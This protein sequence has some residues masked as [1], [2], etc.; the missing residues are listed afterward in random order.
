VLR[1]TEMYCDRGFEADRQYCGLPAFSEWG[2]LTIPLTSRIGS[3][4]LDN[5]FL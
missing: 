1:V 2:P 3:I 5:S 4:R